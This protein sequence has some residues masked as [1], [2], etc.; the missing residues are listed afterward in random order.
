MRLSLSLCLA[1]V[2]LSTPLSS[3]TADTAAT[4]ATAATG[5]RLVAIE[6]MSATVMQEGQ[7]SFS[8][9]ALRARFHSGRFIEGVEFMP[10]VE[11]WRNNSTV[12]SFGIRSTRRDATMA[13]DARYNFKHEGFAPYAG[14]GFAIHFLTNEVDAPSFGLNDAQSSVIKGGV[15]ALGGITFPLSGRLTNFFE[16]KYHHVTDF[17]QLKLNWGL[18]YAL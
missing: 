9:L 10:A 11:W 15:A 6:G 4:V 13:L 14:A 7:S 5:T 18:A 2:A 12:E 16:L 1:V 8:G 17:R 3:A